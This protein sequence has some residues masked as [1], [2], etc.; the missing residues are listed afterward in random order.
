MDLFI[1]VELRSPVK[2][3]MTCG[4]D[5]AMLLTDAKSANRQIINGL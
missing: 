3:G 2:P 1:L 4:T 5:M